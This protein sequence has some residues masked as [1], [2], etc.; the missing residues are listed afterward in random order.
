MSIFQLLRA[1]FWQEDERIYVDSEIYNELKLQGISALPAPILHNLS[2]PDE[3]RE[4]WKK[5]IIQQI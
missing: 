3:L 1:S 2:M 4:K 5:D